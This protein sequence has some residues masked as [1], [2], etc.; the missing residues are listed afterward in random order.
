MA[1]RPGIFP[2]FFMSGFECSTFDWQDQGRRG[3]VAE[4]QHRHYAHEVYAMLTGLGIGVSR[5]GIPW[6]L[7]DRGGEYN[8]HKDERLQMGICDVVE[9][10]GTLRRVPYAPYVQELRRWEKQLNRVTE[11]D[12]DPFDEPVELADVVA[13]AKRLPMQP[14]TNWS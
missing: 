2:T 5:E 14:D 7:V 13:A 9:D 11:L 3:L 10:G 4:T 8:W 12:G 6:P 1:Q